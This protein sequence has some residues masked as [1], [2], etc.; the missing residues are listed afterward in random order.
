MAN[1]ISLKLINLLEK[2]KEEYKDEFPIYIENGKY[3]YTYDKDIAEYKDSEGIPQNLN[4]KESFYYLVDKL[5][6]EGVLSQEDKRLRSI[7]VAS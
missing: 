4:A 3:Y 1:E 7:K 5:I 6:E 2:N